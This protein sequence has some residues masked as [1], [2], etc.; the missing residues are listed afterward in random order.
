MAKI[1]AQLDKATWDS[2][3]GA[4]ALEVAGVALAGRPRVFSTGSCG[5]HVS[6]KATVTL[7]DGRALPCQVS[8]TIVVIG[9]K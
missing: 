4:I 7:A 1:Q 8:A 2:D 3:G 5:W 9:S 6:G